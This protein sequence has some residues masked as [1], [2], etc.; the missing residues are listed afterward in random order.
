MKKIIAAII[1]TIMPNEVRKHKREEKAKRIYYAN[2]MQNLPDNE[3]MIKDAVNTRYDTVYTTKK[4]LKISRVYGM[5]DYNSALALK[6]ADF[7]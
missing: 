4:A 6:N 3:N 2:V 7:R 5:N 1:R